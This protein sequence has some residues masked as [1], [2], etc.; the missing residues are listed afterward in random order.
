MIKLHCAYFGIQNYYLRQA[1]K[2]WLR[3]FGNCGYY[4]R[5]ITKLYGFFFENW[6]YY[7]LEAF[8]CLWCLFGNCGYLRDIS[9]LRSVFFN[10]CGYCL[11]KHLN[12][13]GDNFGN[14]GY[15]LNE[16]SKIKEAFIFVGATF[17]W[18]KTFMF[19]LETRLLFQGGV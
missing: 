11:V 14:W 10:N 12:Y 16:T 9:K 18:F 17:G 8:K 6:D 4:L 13:G 7:L 1:F 5:V 3:L 19:I 15:Y 2:C